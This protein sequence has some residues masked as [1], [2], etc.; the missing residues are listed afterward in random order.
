[1]QASLRPRDQVHD[2][3]GIRRDHTGTRRLLRAVVQ[4]ELDVALCCEIEAERGQRLQ[5]DLRGTVLRVRRVERRQPAHVPHVRRGRLR[6]AL[7]PEQPLEPRLA[8]LQERLLD[9][10]ARGDEDRFQLAQRDLLLLLVPR[11]RI[12]FPAE[13][14]LELLVGAQQFEPLLVEPGRPAPVQ[15]AELVAV[16]VVRDHGEL[17]ERRA[18]RQLLTLERHARG[19]QRIFELVVALGELRRDEAA[20]AR[21]VQ[22]VKPLALVAVTLLLLLAQRL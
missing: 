19:E 7:R 15:L 14:R 11:D 17:C 22:P 20:L 1:M 2:L 9:P 3:R 6:L 8:Q 21:L 4:I 18:Q 5:A 12:R 16:L 10:V 13:V